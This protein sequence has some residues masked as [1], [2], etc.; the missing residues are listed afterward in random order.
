MARMHRRRTRSAR[1]DTA[2]EKIARRRKSHGQRRSPTWILGSRP[3]GEATL[4]W[5][6]SPDVR[7]RDKQS[8][9]NGE[10][11]IM[12]TTAASR[13]AR[14]ELSKVEGRPIC[15]VCVPKDITKD[16]LSRLN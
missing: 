12:P 10:E 4:D 13:I 14:I 11:T 7:S 15:T 9:S 1:C 8:T 5:G 3:P 2:G 6:L 16:E